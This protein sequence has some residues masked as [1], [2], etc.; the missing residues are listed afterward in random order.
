MITI[1]FLFVKKL[2]KR[3]TLTSVLAQ[4]S[5]MHYACVKWQCWRQQFSTIFL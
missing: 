5:V 2:H 3:L 1:L 4:R